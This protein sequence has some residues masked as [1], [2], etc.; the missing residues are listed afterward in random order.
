MTHWL[1]SGIHKKSPNSQIHVQVFHRIARL[2]PVDFADHGEDGFLFMTCVR[3][4]LE[5][6]VPCRFCILL[7]FLVNW[8]TGSVC[9][10]LP[11]SF[12][13]LVNGFKFVV[14][15]L[16]LRI[17][18]VLWIFFFYLIHARR[19]NAK[20]ELTPM[21][22]DKFIFPIADGTVKTPGGDRRQRPSTLIRD[23]PGRGEEQE[24]FRGE[25]DELHSP[26][27]LQDDSTR[28]DEEA[29][30]D[31]WAI[32]GE[33]ICRHHVEPRVKLYVPR[34]E[35]FP[36]PLKYIDVTRT[37]YTSLDVLLE[38]NI[39][40]YWNVDEEKELSDAWT[41]FTRFILLNERPPDAYTWSGV[42]LTRKQTNSRPDDVWP[43]MWKHMS[44][45]AKKKAKQKWAIEKPKLDKARQLIERNILQR[46]KR[47][48]I[49]AHNESR[50]EKVGSSD[51]SS[52]AL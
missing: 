43:D 12:T 37:K 25:S 22:G 47:R 33:F 31:F 48:R 38:K 30:S 20:E 39:E 36:I 24:V 2:C 13:V 50:S 21:K 34:E 17:V 52:N 5:V 7:T 14:P 4:Y 42:R 29:K 3:R 10:G 26:T 40:D 19:L 44:D 23:R 18:G 41:S 45:A 32:T 15:D 46:T 35:S 6:V 1:K 9:K 16:S 27:Q 11:L 49:Q 8:R 28:D 51:A